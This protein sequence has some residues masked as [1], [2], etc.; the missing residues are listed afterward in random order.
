MLRTPSRR[1]AVTD[2]ALNAIFDINGA[3]NLRDRNIRG[4]AIEADVL[5]PRFLLQTHVAG[6]ARGAIVEQDV[7][8]AGVAIFVQPGIELVLQD[9][10][11]V[12]R[13]GAAVATGVY[14][15]AYSYVL[16]RL[17]GSV[18]GCR[19]SVRGAAWLLGG[20][21]DGDESRRQSNLREAFHFFTSSTV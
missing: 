3:G 1:G 10:R 8:R 16:P 21:R 13:L 12:E 14:A 9:A 6:D 19:L 17:R 11:C 7:V 15:A 18:V 5:L 2:L 4:V 20:D